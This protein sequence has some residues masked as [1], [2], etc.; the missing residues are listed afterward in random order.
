MLR[1]EFRRK[2]HT[3]HGLTNSAYRALEDFTERKSL[4]LG[5]EGRV[6]AFIGK[7]AERQR[8]DS[9]LRSH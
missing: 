2:R 9:R 7:V 6:R 5:H 8:E 1:E 3:D 4:R